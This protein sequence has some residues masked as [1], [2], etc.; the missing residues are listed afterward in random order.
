VILAEREDAADGEA[1]APAPGTRDARRIS[2]SS[3][4]V[5]RMGGRNATPEPYAL[6]SKEFLRKM[7]IGKRVR[8]S[9]E[10]SRASPARPADDKRPALPARYFASVFL[11]RGG[12]SKN[13]AEALL[14]AGLGEAVRHR[15]GD[16]RSSHYDA[17]LEAQAA[18]KARAKGIHNDSEGAETIQRIKDVTGG[19]G[20]GGVSATAAQQFV[21][22]LKTGKTHKAIVEYI[23]NAGRF[24][25]FIPKENCRINFQLAGVRVPAT[26]RRALSA[27]DGRAGREAT[28]GEPF[29]L[30]ALA[31][32]RENVMQ[33]S[34]EVEIEDVN[35]S[36]CAIG[37]LRTY[38]GGERYLLSATLLSQGYAEVVPFSASKSSSRAELEIAE[39]EGRAA[40]R[41][42]WKGWEERE[43]SRLAAEAAEESANA[44]K[45]NALSV[46]KDVSVSHIEDGG[47][48]WV[49]YKT[50]A[51]ETEDGAKVAAITARVAADVKGAAPPSPLADPK[52]FDF[53]LAPFDDGQG[54]EFF[55][56]RIEALVGDKAEV[57]FLDHGN[58]A[59]VPVSKLL[60]CDAEV[61][62]I[63]PL[64][65]RLKLAFVRAPGVDEEFGNA[66]GN[67][68]ADLVWGLECQAKVH[69]QENDG[70]LVASLYAGKEDIAALKETSGNASTTAATQEEAEPAVM[71]ADAAPTLAEAAATARRG[72]ADQKKKKEEQSGAAVAAKAAVYTVAEK[73][74][75]KGFV[76]IQKGAAR[77]ATNGESR[78]VLRKMEAAQDSARRSRVG[79]WR[80]GDADS[81]DEMDGRGRP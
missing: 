63:P 71:A 64:A 46:T 73:M 42:L 74:L 21:K 1:T 68:L 7:L 12:N 59:R 18:A 11:E 34:V 6:Q 32:V 16:E 76:R 56:A 79:M 51:S 57:L 66:A 24:K 31:Y 75:Q 13:V 9:I 55:R 52:K 29:G 72:G 5:P 3:V 47:L 4:R 62:A 37:V 39:E 70:T 45:M 15:S 53:C 81:D 78:A 40:E 36:G 67:M 77:D 54:E 50:D 41:G 65:H 49:R 8:V 28:A 17:L 33:R 14:L 44:A 25:L 61:L 60:P 23:H 19:R 69:W 27:S 43:K 10:Y 48:L 35:R 2:L 80:Y 38:R 30:E 20:A 26:P 22:M 58:T